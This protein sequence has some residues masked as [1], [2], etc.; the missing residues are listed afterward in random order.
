M[1]FHIHWDVVLLL[2]LLEGA[3]LLAVGPLRGR[4]VHAT[5]WATIFVGVHVGSIMLDSYTSFG[6]ADV[7][8]P[9]ASSWHPLA[10]AWGVW[11]T[12]VTASLYRAVTYSYRLTDRAVLIDFGFWHPPVVATP[13]LV[14][15]R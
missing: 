7:L 3:Y 2:A 12:L 10:V 9:F 8:V 4:I 14:S 15:C 13:D 11:P 1:D 6:P 5:L